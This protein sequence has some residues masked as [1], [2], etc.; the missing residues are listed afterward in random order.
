MVG[1]R[2]IVSNTDDF[3]DSPLFVIASLPALPVNTVICIGVFVFTLAMVLLQVR[4]YAL[5]DKRKALLYTF[6]ILNALAIVMFILEVTV[7]QK[8]TFGGFFGLSESPG[9]ISSFQGNFT[10]IFWIPFFF[11]ETVSF[12]FVVQKARKSHRD[13]GIHHDTKPS[14]LDTLIRHSIQYYLSI[15]I[16][17]MLGLGLLLGLIIGENIFSIAFDHL[18]F[19]IMMSGI[20]AP[21]LFLSLRK[22]YYSPSDESEG[23]ETSN[24]PTSLFHARTGVSQVFSV[25]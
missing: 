17:Y 2:R 14:L 12:A 7:V 5:C 10:P 20:L 19:S 22:S 15:F 1:F 3:L 25:H 23:L 9:D 24:P 11:N 21:N 8:T 4:A 13:S 16:V 18:F 6:S